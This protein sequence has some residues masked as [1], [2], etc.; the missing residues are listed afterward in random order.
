MRDHDRGGGIGSPTHARGILTRLLRG[1]RGHGGDARPA[2]RRGFLGRLARDARGNTLAIVGAAL[3]PL[4]GMIGSGVDMSRAYMAKT[5]LQSACD[6]SALAGRRIMTNDQMTDTVRAE[7]VRFFNFNFPQ[8]LY[9]TDTF[10]PAVARPVS[11]TVRVTASTTI[12]TSIMKIFGFTSLPL[13]VTCDASLNFVN[14]DVMLVLDVT[15]SM[16][17]NLSGTKKIVSLRDAV[18]A[19]Y[20]ELAPVQAQLETNGLRLRYGVVPYSSTVNVGGLIR[21][22]NPDFLANSVTYQTR[23][24]N[25]ATQTSSSSANGPYWEYYSSTAP[26][27]TS[28]VNQATS[29]TQGNC[30]NFMK[31]LN[32]T[33]FAAT[34]T[35][36]T[37]GG[38]APA[39]TI[40][41]SFPHDGTAT[42][43]GSTGE[44]GWTNAPDTSGTNESC[45][46]KR[47]DTTT[48]YRY[49]FTNDIFQP[50][51]V[52]TS[53]YKMGTAVSVA[54]DNDP[55]DPDADDYSG[56][57]ATPGY[58]NVADLATGGLGHGVTQISQAWNGC[59]EE[60]TTVHTITPTSPADLAIPSGAND[61]N[62]NLIPNSDDTRWRPQWPAMAWYRSAGSATATSG[63]SNATAACPAPAVRLQTWTS[64]A[65]QAYVN[66]L[67]PTGSTYHDIGMLWGARMLSTGGIFADGCENYHGMPCTRHI[68]FM[69][70]GQMDT[71]PSTYSAYGMEK[72]DQ[73]IS[74]MSNP[75]ETELNGRHMQR[76]RMICNAAR[77][78]NISIWVIAF[79]TSLSTDMS[80]CASNSNQASTIGNRDQLI[81]KF[82]EIG[83]N[84]GSLRLTQ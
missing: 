70:D 78:M 45:R 53:N 11:G 3:V 77:S 80:N 69:T 16:D 61:L 38:P 20:D 25:M 14:T 28:N 19:L 7:A 27:Y 84:I 33:G 29:I 57:V 1:A 58:Y 23:R 51:A 56:T 4:A 74:G 32:F 83:N 41:A 60:R 66:A 79:G 81:A 42:A 30:L 22:V 6:A 17:Q 36:P 72:N 75:S 50:L 13:N 48:T 39:P 12:P 67:I 49:A 63:T 44:W 59:I 5:R 43:G 76:F 37:S 8:H 9:G 68:I 62:I 71:D 73:R 82:R 26:Y 54:L 46:R 65:M 15:G 21:G 40:V 47:T 24:A 35:N 64:D 2:P 18:M 31:N 34:P 55:N 10:T 52:D